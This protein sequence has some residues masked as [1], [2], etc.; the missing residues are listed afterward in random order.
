[1]KFKTLTLST[2]FVA[3]FIS[4]SSISYA[5]NTSPTLPDEMI[6]EIFSH[7]NPKEV[8][9]SATVS[10]QF[11]RAACDANSSLSKVK[12]SPEGKDIYQ[13]YCVRRPAPDLQTLLSFARR[14]LAVKN[15]PLPNIISTQ[16]FEAAKDIAKVIVDENTS[17]GTPSYIN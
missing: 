4:F 16:E 12:N 13:F 6:V 9:N 14:V 5:T 10:K 15:N 8:A 1:M 7:F 2:S 11:N 17:T 3:A